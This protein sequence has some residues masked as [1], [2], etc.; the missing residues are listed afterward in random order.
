MLYVYFLLQELRI[1]YLSP[2]VYL[3]PK[4]LQRPIVNAVVWGHQLFY[5]QS[6]KL[7]IDKV[8]KESQAPEK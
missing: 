7:G 6:K 1:L 8:V 4:L 2:L 3:W 5:P